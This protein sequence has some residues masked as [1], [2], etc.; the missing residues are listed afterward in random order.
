MRMGIECA[1]A[2]LRDYDV[3]CGNFDEAGSHACKLV[4]GS[5]Y[6]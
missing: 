6:P 5:G 1:R 2:K 4:G 3:R